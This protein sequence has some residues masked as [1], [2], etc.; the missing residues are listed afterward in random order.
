M[1][2]TADGRVEGTGISQGRAK[3][4]ERRRL[5]GFVV[6]LAALSL[7]F[8][9][10]L[11]RLFA[12]AAHNELYSHI[13]LIPVATL[14]LAMGRLREI[15]PALGSHGC[16][17][18]ACAVMGAGLLS[19]YFCGAKLG[20][21]LAGVDRL[22]LTTGSYLAFVTSGLLL[23]LGAAFLRAIL[24][25]WA[26]L[27]FLVPFPAA[28]EYG[29]EVFF[30]RTSAE[31]AHW[32]MSL[33]GLPFL[34]D[35]LF[36]RLPGILLEVAR[37]CS[38]I[39]SSLVLFITSLVGG[40]ML[41]QRPS[42]RAI[43]ALAVIPLAIVRNSFRIL[44]VAWLCVHIGPEMIHSPIHRRGGPIFFLLS[45]IPFFAL[46]LFLKWIEKRRSRQPILP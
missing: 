42:S 9:F 24:F 23:F 18:L 29:I 11:F 34:R 5:Q 8:A 16:L 13:F 32:L 46:L 17:A 41:L 40:M 43:L 45:L 38:G 35:G 14:Y 20:W 26:L 25:P 33:A 19:L 1:D 10:P 6:F 4:F 22:A 30:Q 3:G 21:T 36:F 12:H 7:A 2:E 37:E 44:T 28:V 39:R 15:K 31:M 27:L